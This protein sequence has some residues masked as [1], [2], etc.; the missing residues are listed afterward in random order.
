MAALWFI[1]GL[2]PAQLSKL[3]D[4]SLTATADLYRSVGMASATV[5]DMV[6]QVR[7]WIHIVPYV[8]PAIVGVSGLLLASVTVALAAAF[9]SRAGEALPGRLRFS[10]F[11]LHWSMAYGFMGGLALVLVAPAFGERVEQV[12]LVG[13]NLLMFFETLFFVQG[14]A[15]AH[16]FVVSRRMAAGRRIVVYAAALLGQLLLQ[17]TS[18]AGLLDTWFDYRKR[19]APR[20]PGRKRVVPADR[21]AGDQEER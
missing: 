13:L 18:W 19:F 11:R 20:G 8:L 21:G 6:A 17:L 14:L 7:E 1:S 9:Y 15:V 5:D 3:V 2:D 10:E 4:D 12:R 16:W